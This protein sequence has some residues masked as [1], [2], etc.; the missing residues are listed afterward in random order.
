MWGKVSASQVIKKQHI[1]TI[2]VT[3]FIEQMVKVKNNEN[4]KRYLGMGNWA[5]PHNAG[6]CVN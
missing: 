5:F 1:K 6:E 2:R 3:E 4:T